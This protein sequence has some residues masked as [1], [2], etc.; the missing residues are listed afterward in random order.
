MD[1]ALSGTIS[2]TQSRIIT[3]PSVASLV[4]RFLAFLIE[5]VVYIAWLALWWTVAVVMFD[6]QFITTHETQD[7]WLASDGSIRSGTSRT[8]TV[9]NGWMGLLGWLAYCAYFLW[10]EVHYGQT[11]G[12]RVLGLHVVDMATGERPSFGQSLTR[13]IFFYVGTVALFILTLIIMAV[14]DRNQRTGDAAAK[15]LVVYKPADVRRA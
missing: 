12:K 10:A 9:G 11:L 6:Q 1:H 13:L 14:S 5:T 7:Y 8:L 3:P 15:T 4:D 2:S